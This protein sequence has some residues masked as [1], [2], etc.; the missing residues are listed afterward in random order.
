MPLLWRSSRERR[1]ERCKRAFLLAATCK[2]LSGPTLVR[3]YVAKSDGFFL[4][5]PA[6]RHPARAQHNGGADASCDRMRR[7]AACQATRSAMHCSP[8]APKATLHA[9]CCNCCSGALL[10]NTA[11]LNTAPHSCARC[12]HS[13]CAHAA[14]FAHALHPT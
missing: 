13:R 6:P 14:R 1:S 8:A 9:T 2:V 3:L 7:C 5:L 10:R 12:T 11:F 4:H